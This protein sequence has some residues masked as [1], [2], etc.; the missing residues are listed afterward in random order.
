MDFIYIKVVLKFLD[1]VSG[2]RQKD[3]K[4]QRTF[5]L[6]SIFQSLDHDPKLLSPFQNNIYLDNE[7]LQKKNNNVNAR[8]NKYIIMT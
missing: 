7:K 6:F 4:Q 1:H 2:N 8:K 5:T 3:L